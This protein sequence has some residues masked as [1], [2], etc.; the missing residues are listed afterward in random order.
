MSYKFNS[1]LEEQQVLV[2]EIVQ[3]KLMEMEIQ[4]SLLDVKQN[5]IHFKNEKHYKTLILYMIKLVEYKEEIIN[6]LI[7][8]GKY[9][10]QTLNKIV[11]QI[12]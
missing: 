1:Y 9:S 12:D 2:D 3:Y 6:K 5:I 10:R 4:R 11:A 8:D 7:P